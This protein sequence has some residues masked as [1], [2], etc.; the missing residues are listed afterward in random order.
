ML[1]PRGRGA[2]WRFTAHIIKRVVMCRQ[3]THTPRM[4][5]LHRNRERIRRRWGGGSVASRPGMCGM[6]AA[7]YA[8]MAKTAAGERPPLDREDDWDAA[9][10]AAVHFIRSGGPGEMTGRQLLSKA[11]GIQRA[12]RNPRWGNTPEET[13]QRLAVEFRRR[14]RHR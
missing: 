9:L 10:E 6:R 4:L 14:G 8:E 1:V 3:K 7:M 2:R 13:C 11:V 5:T 12:G